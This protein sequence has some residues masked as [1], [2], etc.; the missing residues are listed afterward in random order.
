MLKYS[1]AVHSTSELC[2]IYNVVIEIDPSRVYC[3]C[4]GYR[5]HGYCKHI[6]I[7]KTLIAKVLG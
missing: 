4:L 2:K 7:Y 5:S 6:K 3:D 1:F